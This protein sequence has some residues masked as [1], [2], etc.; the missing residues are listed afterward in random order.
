ME[1][2]GAAVANSF[3][4]AQAAGLSTTALGMPSNWTGLYGWNDF[5]LYPADSSCI[6]TATV[7]YHGYCA[8]LFNH[9]T[10]F[11]NGIAKPTYSYTYPA[12]SGDNI[13]ADHWIVNQGPIPN[14]DWA[15]STPSGLGHFHWGWKYGTKIGF[16][17]DTTDTYYPGKFPLD[18]WDVYSGASQSGTHRNAFEIHG[19]INAH[20]F[21][22]TPTFGCIRLPAPS[23]N[24]VKYQWVNSTDNK[25]W[26]PGPDNLV[27]YTKP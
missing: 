23:V 27:H 20:D 17:K 13:P 2:E 6:G 7:V 26:S 15:S 21:S 25:S 8:W 1:A 14:G 16:I 10:Q 12:R 3:A 22:T 18:P 4:G 24:G 9:V 11:V 19:G 5:N